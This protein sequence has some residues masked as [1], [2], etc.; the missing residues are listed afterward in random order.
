MC[1]MCIVY[2]TVYNFSLNIYTTGRS[3]NQK[4]EV[5]KDGGVTEKGGAFDILSSFS[6]QW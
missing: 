3:E 2:C 1:S 5:R 6:G 4:K